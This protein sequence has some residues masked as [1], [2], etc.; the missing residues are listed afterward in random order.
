[1]KPPHSPLILFSLEEMKAAKKYV[2]ELVR[3]K[4]IRSSTSPY[5]APLFFVKEK[6]KLREVVDHRALNRIT[7]GNKAPLS[8][9][10]EIFDRLGEARYFSK[11]DLKTGFH[12][13]WV[14]S[15]DIEK[16]AFITEYGQFQYPVIPMGL[17][18]APAAFQAL[19]SQI[20]CDCFDFI[21]VVYMDGLQ[22]FS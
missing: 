15:Q 17:C 16:T 11:L 4:K 22:N 13:I 19:M 12:Q 14:N 3:K 2:E 5:G 1:M 20:F 21:L 8:R 6:E 10:D 7:K 9:S 18:D